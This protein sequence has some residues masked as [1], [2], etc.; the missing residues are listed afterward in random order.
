MLIFDFF[1][2][3]VARRVGFSE[4]LIK[5]SEHVT[6]ESSYGRGHVLGFT[7]LGGR[8][9]AKKVEKGRQGLCFRW[10]SFSV[11]SLTEKR[12]HLE[13]ILLSPSCAKD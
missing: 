12:G 2:I 11:W 7:H 4:R 6:K 5:Y 10:K 1:L 13:I 3:P 9:K 8:E